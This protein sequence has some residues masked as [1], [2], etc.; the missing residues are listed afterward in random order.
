M[1]KVLKLEII[2][3]ILSDIEIAKIVESYFT[4]MININ[5]SNS[6]YAIWNPMV[7]STFNLYEKGILTE[8]LIKFVDSKI[9]T[10]VNI[11]EYKE[12]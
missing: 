1:R 9:T 10:G 11:H 6:E 8:E 2:T 12:D 7:N 3:N 4:S 5:I